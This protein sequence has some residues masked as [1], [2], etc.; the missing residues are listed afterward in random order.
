MRIEL[1]NRDASLKVHVESNIKSI[2]C[3]EAT[4]F[5]EEVAAEHVDDVS[6]IGVEWPD[7]KLVTEQIQV[8]C[9]KV[10]QR[11]DAGIGLAVV[12][13]QVTFKV[14]SQTGDAPIE[15]ALPA[16]CEPAI[17]LNLQRLIVPHRIWE[18]I[19]LSIRY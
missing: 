6:A 1:V 18:T 19:R 17:Q 4:F 7:G 5:T 2:K 12:I 16:V 8:A 11:A 10:K 9:G 15:E 3:A 14:A 13:T